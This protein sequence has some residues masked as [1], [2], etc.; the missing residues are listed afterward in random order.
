MAYRP[1]WILDIY[2]ERDCK[3]L[4]GCEITYYQS[5]KA[6]KFSLFQY[7]DSFEPKSERKFDRK[8]K[9]KP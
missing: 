3:A 6:E 2:D 7:S 1:C 9:L 5:K 4:L 8:P